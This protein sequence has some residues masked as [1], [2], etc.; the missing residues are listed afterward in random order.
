M[1]EGRSRISA[2]AL[3]NLR[4]RLDALPARHPDRRA[5]LDSAAAL[6]GLSRATLYRALRQHLRP[7]SV[8]RTDRGK[9]RKLTMA[10]MERYCE[11]VAALKIRTCNR[12]GRHLS[13][14]RAIEL[15][16]AHGVETPDG[17]V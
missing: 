3:V 7:K 8:R 9:P 2:E 5:M 10:E 12:K 13:T 6:Y 15:M 1:A 4:R 11:I 14:V 16:E 17:L